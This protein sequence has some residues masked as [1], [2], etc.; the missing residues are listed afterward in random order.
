MGRDQGI[1]V[2][3]PSQTIIDLAP[4]LTERQLERLI[5]EADK[6]DLV[7]PETLR[8]A[9]A[10]QGGVGG[11]RVRTLLD[12]RTFLLTDSGLER[13]FIPIAESAGMS[14]PETQV[15]VN[16]H[17][18]DFIFRAEG[19][20]VETDGGRYHRTPSQQR[21][22]R[23]RE[24]AHALAELLPIRFTHDQIAHEPAYVAEVLRGL[25]SNR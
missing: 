1:P 9:A 24:H 11:S 20:V 22:D 15:E 5:D 7:H 19:V 25:S 16:G 21:R 12:R 3:S 6:R 18:V 23:I 4:S 13:L 14:R 2:T 8:E 10:A 17:R